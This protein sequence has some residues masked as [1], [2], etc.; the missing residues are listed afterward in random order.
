MANFCQEVLKTLGSY[1][2][3]FTVTTKLRVAK[4]IDIPL[5]ITGIASQ[6]Q[7]KQFYIV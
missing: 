3:V 2:Q 7:G 5:R 4:T 1:T 6:G